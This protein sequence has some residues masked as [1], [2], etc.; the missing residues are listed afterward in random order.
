M[1]ALTIFAKGSG[2]CGSA[3]TTEGF[4]LPAGGTGTLPPR[5]WGR[6]PCWLIGSSGLGVSNNQAVGGIRVISGAD[7]TTLF[8]YTASAPYTGLGLVVQVLPGF[9]FA[10]GETGFLDPISHGYG[11]AHVW[12]V[13]SDADGDGVLDADDA[14][15][16]SIM[17]ATVVILGIDSGV[18]NRVNE[19]GITLAD[20]FAAPGGLADYKVP[21]LYYVKVQQLST[22]LAKANLLSKAEDRAISAAA[23]QGALHSK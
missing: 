10:A 9:G 8:E 14:I 11:L 1:T 17:D 6:Y 3:A 15:P 23:R 13:N 4:V 18:P 5:P 20:R 19:Q 2:C 16:H 12:K 7:R 21:A 22:Q